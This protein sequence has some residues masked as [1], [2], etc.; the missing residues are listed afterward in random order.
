MSP[1]TLLRTDLALLY[2]LSHQH[3]TF[4]GCTAGLGVTGGQGGYGA[5]Q[6]QGGSAHS[7]DPITSPKSFSSPW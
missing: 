5:L 1:E 3:H 2:Q 4:P 7:E 6:A